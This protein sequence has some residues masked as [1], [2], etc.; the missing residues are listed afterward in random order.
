MAPSPLS[1]SPR[2][3]VVIGA[4]F[5]GLNA[6]RAL[7]G[8]GLDVTV[9]DANNYHL[10]QPLLYQVAIAGLDDDNIAYPTR[11]IL[12]RLDGVRFRLGHVDGIDPVART[13]SLSDGATLTYDRL[14]LCA[15]A[16]TNTFGVAG[17]DTHAFGLKN[18]ADA[19][20]VRADL[21]RRFEAAAAEAARG[22]RIEGRELS[23]VIVGGGPTGVELAGGMQELLSRVLRHDY[24]ELPVDAATVTLVEATDRVLG[25][26]AP[27]LSE[28]ALR[29]LRKRHVAVELSASVA[30]IEQ[31]VVV[32]AD[33]R[34]LE[35]GTIVWAAG[36]KAAP[37][38]AASGLP[39]GRGGRIVVDEQLRV[40]GHPEIRVVGDIAATPDGQG[41][42]L[43]QVAQVAIQGGRYAGRAI[44]AE[45][46]GA[47]GPAP[48]R[49]R[50]KGS[51]ATI[52]RRAAVSQFPFGL[53]L[54]GSLGWLAW[55]GLHL[56]YLIGF[57]NRLNVLVNWSWNY[58]TYDH[59]SRLLTGVPPERRHQL[60]PP[61]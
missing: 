20:A 39:I 51:M 48:F 16:V 14:V 49:Y 52:G 5:G 41:G 19:E 8:H 17:A 1:E 12:R 60:D 59:A 47:G 42:V 33:G 28:H 27:S 11:A 25:T 15:G 30:R 4:G 46:A 7:A 40:A 23:V 21:L 24:P 44:A 31:G 58:L 13:V 56:L 57:R 22:R 3:V 43:P 29:T 32:L 61:G 53:R 10:F 38:A 35:A 34:R 18:L 55:L 36:V 6:A 50:D 37:L 26:F 9:V 2:R 45:A 54:R